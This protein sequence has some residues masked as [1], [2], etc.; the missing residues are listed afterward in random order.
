[1]IKAR[2]EGGKPTSGAAETYERCTVPAIYAPWAD[3]LVR[4]AD[5]RFGER[6][7]EV[8]CGTGAVTRSAAELVGAGGRV[9]G[10]DVDARML[11]LARSAARG[12]GAPIEWEEGSATA[13]PFAGGIFDVVFCQQGLQLFSD[14]PAALREMRRVLAPD[15]RLALS[16]W[17][18]A[19]QSPGFAALERALARRIGARAAIL[20]AFSLG[21]AEDLRELLAQT[22]FGETS[23]RISRKLAR[24][25]SVGGFVECVAAGGPSMLGVFG[26]LDADAR[27]ALVHEI[28]GELGPYV[29]GAGLAFPLESHLVV[30]RG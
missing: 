8:A 7:L 12:P 10:I 18:A 14:R 21:S 30:A 26:H 3:D 17:R 9:V 28:E 13:I 23:V 25:P 6:V 16:V 19:E 1:V 5:V 4:L 15:G 2:A 22:G 11:R 20:P 29:D 27:L 24:F